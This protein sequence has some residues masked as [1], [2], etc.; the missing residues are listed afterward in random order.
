MYYN[1]FKYILYH[2]GA[3]HSSA[4]A[5]EVWTARVVRALHQATARL[6]HGEHDDEHDIEHGVEHDDEHGGEHDDEHGV[7]HDDESYDEYCDEYDDYVKIKMNSTK[8]QP[9][10][11]TVLILLNMINYHW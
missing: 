3:C 2:Q 5:A 11:I 4:A 7:E 10:W 9:G 8:Q 1:A 6:D